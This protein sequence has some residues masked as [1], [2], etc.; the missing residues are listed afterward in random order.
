[1][2]WF[3]QL[4]HQVWWEETTRLRGYESAEDALLR[5]IFLGLERHLAA[6]GN[7]MVLSRLP[8]GDVMRFL[9]CVR[10]ALGQ[11]EPLRVASQQMGVNYDSMRHRFKREVGM[12]PKQYVMHLRIQ[13]AKHLLLTTRLSIKE[14]ADRLGYADGRHF[15]AVFTRKVG[16]APQQWRRQPTLRTY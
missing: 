16:F 9:G 2:L 10:D 11:P 13:Q 5:L 1:M 6:T 4:F 12:S 8:A 14:I 3:E 7:E 15:T